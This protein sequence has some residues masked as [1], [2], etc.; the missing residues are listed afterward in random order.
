MMKNFAYWNNLALVQHIVLLSFSQDFTNN[1]SLN[2][3]LWN[4]K[5]TGN[6]IMQTLIGWN[7]SY[8]QGLIWL[9]PIR[10]GLNHK[11]SYC[12]WDVGNFENVEVEK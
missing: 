11:S 1:F 6:D 5:K 9:S 2:S 12:Q 10:D 7:K 4:Y 8:A 3:W